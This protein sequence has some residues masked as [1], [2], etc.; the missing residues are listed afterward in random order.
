MWL[1]ACIDDTSS[2]PLRAPQSPSERF[3]VTHTRRSHV[4][5]IVVASFRCSTCV[6]HGILVRL[7]TMA[8]CRFIGPFVADATWCSVGSGQ[9]PSRQVDASACVAI[10]W[11][12]LQGGSEARQV[13]SDKLAP[14]S[15]Q[16][17]LGH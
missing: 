12:H 8:C 11:T 6:C 13:G 2:E 3:R 17:D 5:S 4:G 10:L 16:Q 14:S 9:P 7:D 15:H 1:L